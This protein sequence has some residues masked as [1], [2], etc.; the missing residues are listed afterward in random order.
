MAEKPRA[1]ILVD[2]NEF[3]LHIAL[4]G[5]L[6]VTL[7]FTSPSRRF[8]LSVIALVVTEMKRLGRITSIPLEEHLELL[9]LLNETIGNAGGSSEKEH[10]LPRI[11]RKW[12]DA[13]PDLEHAPLFKILG[14]KRD[15][16]EGFGL[17]YHFTDEQK[18]AWANL[19]AYRGSEEHVRLHFSI[20]KLGIGLDDVLITYGEEPTLAD[21]EAWQAFT[22]DLQREAK[23][24]LEPAS[25]AREG[26]TTPAPRQSTKRNL[27]PHRWRLAALAAVIALLAAFVVM[28]YAWYAHYEE[29]V[30]SENMAFPLPD[31]PSIAVLPFINMSGD[32][33]QE[34]LSDGITEQI[35]SGLSRVPKLFVI[36][37][38][39]TFTFKGRATKVQQVSRDLGVRYVMEGSVHR[40]DSR[41]RVTAQL[42]DA[43]TGHHLWA[44]RYDRDLQDIFAIQ[45]EITLEIIKAMQVE[46]TMG[47]TA[48]VTGKGTKNLDAYLRALQAQE[49]WY[50]MD[51]EG[52][53]K[54]RELATEAIALDPEYGY[55]YAIVAWCHMLDV[56]YHYTRSPEGSMSR[57]VEAIQKAL[58]LDVSDHRIHRVLSNLC[59]MQG[60]HDKA[61][62]SSKRALELCPGGAAAYEN[63]GVAL[64]FGCRPSE[65]IPM[66]EKAIELDPFPPAV[67]HRNLAMA[68]RH[69]GRYEDTIVEGKKAFQINPKDWTGPF[70]VV[71]AYAKL[72]RKDEARATAA[73]VLRINPEFSLDSMAQTWTRMFATKCHSDRVYGDIEFLRKMDVGL[74]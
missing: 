10:L 30:S 53:T 66:L 47:E 49:Q 38:H 44:Q 73:E 21:D 45:D 29:R 13:L 48:R 34:Y 60:K 62:A 51:K 39:S 54:A 63:L 46:L 65:A 16:K 37:H 40:S 14:R 4:K 70:N 32:P 58:A 22:A 12:K 5:E 69:V 18:D 28:R 68:Y 36:A 43:M 41:I 3:K 9:G 20:D 64:L 52:S 6:E 71:I 72:D 57:A 23:N 8:Y 59:V 24:T 35:I 50:R 1:R 26:L 11:Y 56:V 27:W 42:I 74:K 55:P 25:R 61:I 67:F 33:N 17:G 2:L 15:S 19:F 7:Q 31:K